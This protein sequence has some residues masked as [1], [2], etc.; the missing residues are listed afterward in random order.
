MDRAHRI[1]KNSIRTTA[2]TVYLVA[3][4]LSEL[5][6]RSSGLLLG[7]T[8]VGQQRPLQNNHADQKIPLCRYYTFLTQYTIDTCVLSHNSGYNGHHLVA[9]RCSGIWPSHLEWNGFCA[10]ELPR[11]GSSEYIWASTDLHPGSLIESQ[12]QFRASLPSELELRLRGVLPSGKN[13]VNDGC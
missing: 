1:F 2:L 13:A 4:S 9:V 12:P 10:S 6:N 7:W 11:P 8:G 3:M 5:R